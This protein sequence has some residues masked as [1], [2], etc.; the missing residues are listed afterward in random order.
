VKEVSYYGKYLLAEIQR[1][2]IDKVV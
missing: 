2:V 1:L